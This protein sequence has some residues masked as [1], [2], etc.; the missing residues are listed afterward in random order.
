MLL[1][2]T[3]PNRIVGDR[4]ARVRMLG[5][6]GSIATLV[7]EVDRSSEATVRAAIRSEGEPSVPSNFS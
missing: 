3:A 7:P 2:T 1:R 5:Y 4:E 6:D